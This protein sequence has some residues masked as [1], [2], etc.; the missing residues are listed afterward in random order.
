M[1]T[2][3]GM[4]YTKD[5]AFLLG[6][7][8]IGDGLI[9]EVQILETQELSEQEQARYLIPGLVDI[10]FHGAAGYDFCDGLLQGNLHS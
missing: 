5:C 7:V 8:K 2:L 10:H 4:V 6:I 9:Q 1:T 3:R